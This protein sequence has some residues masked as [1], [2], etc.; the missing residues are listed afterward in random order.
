MALES[1]SQVRC[2]GCPSRGILVER[3]LYGDFNICLLFNF[4]PITSYLLSKHLTF[5][6]FPHLRHLDFVIFHWEIV[7]LSSE[8]WDKHYIIMFLHLFLISA[9]DERNY[10]RS[11]QLFGDLMSSHGAQ[12]IIYFWTLNVRYVLSILGKLPCHLTANFPQH[13]LSFSHIILTILSETCPT[14]CSL[15]CPGRDWGLSTITAD[16]DWPRLSQATL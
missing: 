9:R 15:W 3:G 16:S 5:Q 10:V 8:K 4:D 6:L 1:T 2:P 11:V 7:L 14:L 12:V 13:S